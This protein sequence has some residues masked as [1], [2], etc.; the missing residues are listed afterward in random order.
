LQQ[1]IFWISAANPVVPI[2]PAEALR[3]KAGILFEPVKL[4]VG[5][6]RLSFSDGG[7]APIMS[8]EFTS[9]LFLP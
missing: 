2:S 7:L 1:I 8:T 5:F 3:A 9:L 4:Q 6:A